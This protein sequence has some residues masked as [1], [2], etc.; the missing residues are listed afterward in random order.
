M[1]DI[2]NMSGSTSGSQ[3]LGSI[4]IHPGSSPIMRTS[5]NDGVYDNSKEIL[6]TSI[7]GEYSDRFDDVL[8]YDEE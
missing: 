4:T 6:I 3:T 1:T 7:T 5:S 8:Y 2:V